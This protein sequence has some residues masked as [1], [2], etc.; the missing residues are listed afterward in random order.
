MSV[1]DTLLES[2]PVI[3]RLTKKYLLNRKSKYS[4]NGYIARY[5]LLYDRKTKTWGQGVYGPKWIS[6]HYTMM[7][8]RYMEINPTHPI[9]HEALETLLTHEWKDHGMYNKKTHQD[10]CV[11]G[12][13]LNL[14][15]YGYSKSDKIHEMID[16]ILDHTMSDGGWN[17][18]WERQPIPKIS[19]VHT[20]LSVLEGLSIYQKNGYTYRILEIKEA[21]LRG[22]EVLLSRHLIFIKD[23]KNPIHPSMAKATYPP[24]WK[25][26]YLRALEFLA[27]IKYP[28]DLRMSE[29]IHILISQ[30]KGPYMLK[31][32]QISGLIHFPLETSTYGMFNTLRALKVLQAYR[33]PLYLKL[34]AT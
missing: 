20:T 32:S 7:E 2:D 16:Y 28:D 19:S 34:I 6:T 30:M 29:A 13:L 31:G 11:V 10:M 23:T 26:D 8:L 5:L 14:A 4:D 25:Y 15:C 9:Y 33:Y 22:I 21:I 17:C 12:M 1:L 24:R 18:A 3:S 27:D